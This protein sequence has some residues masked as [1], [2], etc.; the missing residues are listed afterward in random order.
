MRREVRDHSLDRVR[1]SA[2]ALKGPLPLLGLSRRLAFFEVDEFD[3]SAGGS[4][5]RKAFSMLGET[6]A[7]IA[8]AA[9]IV[10]TIGTA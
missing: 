1:P 9:V 3:R 8:G 7:Q 4:P 10:P 5:G 6:P 2:A